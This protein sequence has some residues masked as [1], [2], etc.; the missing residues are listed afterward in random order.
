[1]KLKCI[2]DECKYCT[3][4]MFM[5]SARECQFKRVGF[6]KDAEIDCVIDKE[7]KNTKKKATKIIKVQKIYRK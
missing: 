7:I 5:C 6:N 1:M 2:K 3:E 4:H